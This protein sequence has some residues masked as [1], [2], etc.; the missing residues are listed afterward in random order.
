M[1]QRPSAWHRRHNRTQRAF[2]WFAALT[3]ARSRSP[4]GTILVLMVVPA[5][6]KTHVEHTG[7]SHTTPR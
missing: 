2:I 1:K 4:S 6:T 5:L 3:D 7:A